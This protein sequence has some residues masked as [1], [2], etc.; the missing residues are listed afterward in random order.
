MPAYNE[1]RANAASFNT[2]FCY[3]YQFPF[4]PPQSYLRRKWYDSICVHN[5]QIYLLS[6]A[7]NDL[8]VNIF[9][10]PTI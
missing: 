9:H 4:S 5:M 10:N 8:C 6:L 1:N 3:T 2:V 7:K